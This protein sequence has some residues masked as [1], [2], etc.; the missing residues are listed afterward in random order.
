MCVRA[1]AY[2]CAYTLSRAEA[3]LG[4]PFKESMSVPNGNKNVVNLLQFI[5]LL[6]F[7]DDPLGL[8]L[9]GRQEKVKC[10]GEVLGY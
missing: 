6:I 2:V 3:P 5:K 1:H 8:F 9:V 7:L 10:M 4:N